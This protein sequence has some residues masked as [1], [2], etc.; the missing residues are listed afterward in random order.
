MA[1]RSKYFFSWVCGQL[2][3]SSGL[4]QLG[5][6]LCSD[7]WDGLWLV[8]G[9]GCSL[10]WKLFLFPVVFHPPVSWP[11]K[12]LRVPESNRKNNVQ[13]VS[14]GEASDL[15]SC[16]VGQNQSLGQASVHVQGDRPRAWIQGDVKRWTDSATSFSLSPKLRGYLLSLTFRAYTQSV[17]WQAYI[18]RV[19]DCGIK[20]DLLRVT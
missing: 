20:Q 9:V 3:G 6:F 16:P 15:I 14:A 12:H 5:E 4:C 13:Y 7:D 8:W 11:I 2:S 18:H 10:R 1:S 19:S 17:R